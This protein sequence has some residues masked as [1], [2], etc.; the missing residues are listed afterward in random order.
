MEEKRIIIGS[1]YAEKWT[2]DEKGHRTAKVN[3]AMEL[4]YLF[5]KQLEHKK[6]GVKS[7]ISSYSGQVP[8][9]GVEPARFPTG[10]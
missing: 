8:S 5:N 3:S 1:T 7:K 6:T 9:A 4:I 2:F 10:V